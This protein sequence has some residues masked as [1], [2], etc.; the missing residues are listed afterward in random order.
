[1][2][3]FVPVSPRAA[4]HLRL[5]VVVLSA[6]RGLAGAAG[7]LKD[8][9]RVWTTAEAVLHRIF[10]KRT[11]TVTE[12][13]S[14]LPKLIRSA[15][16]GDAVTIRRHNETVAY[17]LSRARMEAIVETLEVLGNPVAM[18]AIRAYEAGK[19]KL[20]PVSVLDDDDE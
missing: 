3:T 15:E 19:T 18:R 16:K 5:R 9:L 14:Q 12:A 4:A 8:L 2:V 1:M 20:F 13:Q 10:V 6:V 11:Y 7:V 17:V